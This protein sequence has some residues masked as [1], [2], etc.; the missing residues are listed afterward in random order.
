MYRE[1][2]ALGFNVIAVDV[3]DDRSGTRAFYEEFGFEIPNVFD[4][5]NV[6]VKPVSSGRYAHDLLGRRGR[7]HRLASLRLSCRARRYRL[8]ERIE[9]I[10][11]G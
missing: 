11:G 5:R 7:A 8:R 9:S 1:M 2:K 10:L 4:T 3:R 6:S